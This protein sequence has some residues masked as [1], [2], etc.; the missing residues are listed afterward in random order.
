MLAG[1]GIPRDLTR[2]S[3]EPKLDGWRAI[4]T[5]DPTLP[6]PVTIRSRRGVQLTDKLPG[7][8]C[9]G[10]A[11]LRV[12]LDGELVAEAGRASD[13]YALLPR[14]ADARR[15]TP[16]SF[17][18]FDLLWLDGQPIVND[19]YEVRRTALE[20]LALAGPCGVVP[21]F[22]GRDTT[23]LLEVCAGLDVEGLVLKRLGSRYRPGRSSDWRKVKVA[24]WKRVHS[25]RRRPH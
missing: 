6:E 19:S 2:W 1:W 3:A 22:P 20:G 5:V 8:A 15:A 17:W 11:G 24:D 14:L 7:L 13:F 23:T 9:L 21:Q 16:L 10:E 25:P 12:V 18:A 4:V